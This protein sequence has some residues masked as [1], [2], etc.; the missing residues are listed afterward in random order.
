MSKQVETKPE[1]EAGMKIAYDDR[2]R[3]V[4]VSFRG[5]LVVLPEPCGTRE[6]AQAEGESYCR[7]LGYSRSAAWD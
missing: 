1:Y 2:S 4:V 3:R 7:R 5:R 6:E